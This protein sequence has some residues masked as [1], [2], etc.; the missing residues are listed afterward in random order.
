MARFMP[1][2]AVSAASGE[3]ELR[4]WLVEPGQPFTA[5]QAIVVVETEKAVVDIEAETDGVLLRTLCAPGA[6]VAVGEPIA[7]LG[8]PGESATE[9]GALLTPAPVPAVGPAPTVGSAAAP[10]RL[11]SSPLARRLAREAGLAVE[12][13]AGSGPDGRIVRRDVVAAIG[14]RRN[15]AGAAAGPSTKPTPSAEPAPPAEPAPAAESMPAAKLAGAA[16]PARAAGFVDVPHSRMRR[17][18]AARLSLSKATIPHFHLRGTCRVDRLLALRTE[19]NAAGD[20]RISVNDLVLKAAARAHRLVPEMNV[21]W[22]DEAIRTFTE[23]DLAVAVATGDGLL[24]P[25][26]R[27]ADR[28]TVTDLARTT[29]ELAARAKA[30]SLRQHELEGG[31]MT[32]TNLGMFGTQEFAAII[33]PPQSAILA[34]GATAPAPVVVDDRVTAATVMRVTLSVDHRPI[35]GVVAAQWMRAFTDLVESPVRILA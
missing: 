35:D 16:G 31:T 26:V 14:R 13:L 7:V 19:L 6:T 27:G 10:R 18:I 33:N 8:E 21:V 25:V 15:G 17:A 20:T 24:T 1:M 5:G 4:Q 12:D 28:K 9:A 32:V 3:A 29:R 2:P 22:T 23:V 11:F 30:G 34:V